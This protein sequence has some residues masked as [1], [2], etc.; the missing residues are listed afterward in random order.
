M[1]RCEAPNSA[2]CMGWNV[3]TNQMQCAPGHLPES[4]VC[5]GCIAGWF[6]DTLYKC[7]KCPAD[8]SLGAQLQLFWQAA[9]V[10]IGI[11]VAQFMAVL[12][13]VRL[14][15]IHLSVALNRLLNFVL[16]FIMVVQVLVQSAG[17]ISPSIPGWLRA[18]LESIRILQFEFPT[19]RAGG[20]GCSGSI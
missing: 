2:R 1:V 17:T 12:L 13:F 15:T 3:A 19:V 5:A 16:W 20:C 14:R 10:L 18:P 6:P 8:V 4:P 9:G 7:A 11:L